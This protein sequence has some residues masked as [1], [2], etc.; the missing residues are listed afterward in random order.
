MGK[1]A[2]SL[3][4][5][6]FSLE[7]RNGRLLLRDKPIRLRRKAREVLAHLA[8][9]RVRLVSTEE[10]LDTL[11]ADVAVTPH[12]VTSIIRNLRRV[13]ASD[14]SG[15]C[16]IETERGSGY[17]LVVNETPRNDTR[18]APVFAQQ[19]GP[20]SPCV[21]R[22]V[23]AAKLEGLWKQALAGAHPGRVQREIVRSLHEIAQEQ[24]VV[25]VVEDLHWADESTLQ[26][27]HNLTESRRSGRLLVLATFRTVE[28]MLAEATSSAQIAELCA[29]VR[30]APQGREFELEPWGLHAPAEI[31]AMFSAGR[32]W[33][34]AAEHWEL[35]AAK[36][37]GLFSYG[38]AAMFLRHAVDCLHNLPSERSH[39]V[40]LANRKRRGRGAR[41]LP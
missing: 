5:G 21:A 9:H 17:R 41:Y 34:R 29:A 37:A 28:A 14:P 40:R 1:S 16:R 12:V 24:P 7:V 4:F 6:P 31:A 8:E 15:A 36:A 30:R 35:A 23:E 26:F 19:D 3:S 25:L 22:D 27:L 38:E 10:L 33:D 32:T 39:D 20:T 2:E 11:W 13:L 18:A